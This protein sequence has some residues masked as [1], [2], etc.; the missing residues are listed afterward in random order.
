MLAKI[1]VLLKAVSPFLGEA[2]LKRVMSDFL[3][4]KNFLKEKNKYLIQRCLFANVCFA[5]F[6]WNFFFATP[7][8]IFI[9][10]KEEFFGLNGRSLFK[11]GIQYS[12]GCWIALNIL[13]LCLFVLFKNSIQRLTLSLLFSISISS[14]IN[15]TFL[16]GEYG[17]F[18]GRSNVSINRFSFLSFVQ[19]GI[20]LILLTVAL[21]LRKN[22]KRLIFVCIFLLSVNVLT[23][24]LNIIMFKIRNVIDRTNF[25]ADLFTYL[26]KHFDWRNNLGFFPFLQIAAFVAALLLVFTFRKIFKQPIFVYITLFLI[27]ISILTGIVVSKNKITVSVD[28]TKNREDFFIY[29]AKN[30]NILMIM[31]DEYQMEFFENMLNDEIKKQLTGF[32]WYRNTISNYPSTEVSIPMIFTGEMR[33]NETIKKYYKLS[34]QKSIAKRFEE[35]S[36]QT[37][38]VLDNAFSKSRVFFSKGS[39]TRLASNSGGHSSALMALLN[40]SIFK[41][42]PDIIKPIVYNNGKWP[43]RYSFHKHK[44]PFKNLNSIENI[45]PALKHIVETRPLIKKDYPATLKYYRSTL[46]HAPTIFDENCNYIGL[47]PSTLKKK[48]AEGRCAIKLVIDIINNLK[49]TGVFDNTM[50]LLFSDHG[51][52]FVPEIFKKHKQW[53]PYSKASSTL[54]IKPLGRTDLFKI[55]NYPAQL[56]DIPKTIAQAVGLRDDYAGVDLLSNDRIKSRIRI[57]S[58]RIKDVPLTKTNKYEIIKLSND[59]RNW[60]KKNE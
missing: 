55:D 41:N 17:V 16:I 47:V 32:I 54:L 31:L 11:T 19:I 18:D 51:S 59:P 56:G 53:F 1:V 57:F 15:A 34:N 35:I 2:P 12:V 46:T 7:F 13:L 52:N 4:I 6:I 36:G 50:I 37:T 22:L 26:Y 28:T 33:K 42:V 49:N 3:Q 27:S 9:A 5:L 8:D 25:E 29:S 39:Y 24:M 44:H 14:W 30:P 40:Y 43:I 60:R 45:Y 20:F 58:N 38:F 10:N 23:S 48:T 21:L